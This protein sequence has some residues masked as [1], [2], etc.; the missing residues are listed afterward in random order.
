MTYAIGDRKEILKS[1][2]EISKTFDSIIDKECLNNITH[3]ISNNIIQNLIYS[4]Y[5]QDST[6]ESTILKMIIRSCVVSESMSA[7]SGELSIIL[8]N[9]F[10]KNRK[11]PD[12][13]RER[14]ELIKS[15]KN[16]I[17][18][19]SNYFSKY[20]KKLSLSDVSR[21]IETL[22]M[23]ELLSENIKDAIVNC[24]IGCNFIVSQSNC[25]ET[26]FLK[27]AGNRL[28]IDVEQLAATS[29]NRWNRNY[30]NTILIDGVIE[31]VSQIH[32]LLEL[33]SSKKEPFL[34]IC[35]KA[36]DEVKKTIYLNNIRSTIDLVIAEINFETEF[37]HFF[38]DMAALFDC[39][40]VNINMGDTVSAK[41]NN[42]IF[43]LDRIE[44]CP[45]YINFKSDK[46]NKDHI[47]RY[48]GEIQSIKTNFDQAGD[49]D[50]FDMVSRSI[51]KRVKFLSSK[52]IEIKIGQE[53][54]IYNKHTVSKIDTFFR[55]FQDIA[56]TGIVDV[57]DI[58]IDNDSNEIINV[59][60]DKY[61]N[62]ILTQRQI[63]QSLVSAFKLY[64]T[65]IKTEKIF[66]IS[67]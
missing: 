45:K 44:I 11:M 15:L 7:G 40:F 56:L 47:Y 38:A 51:D 62:K 18:Y 66:T 28:E 60:V 39:D 26:V 1:C 30:V 48:I 61:K 23:S 12:S 53:D 19:S 10:L 13:N 65:I 21:V 41:M 20:L 37:H 31:D 3:S 57:A 25:S 14:L 32:H 58:D 54:K 55:S 16:D 64:E 2:I 8:L 9:N 36:S 49:P 5:F 6:P 63:F 22:N 17:V 4:S 33:S 52:S 29:I 46:R 67:K 42:V 27:N 43:I 59:I 50:T 35:R 24:E 34:I